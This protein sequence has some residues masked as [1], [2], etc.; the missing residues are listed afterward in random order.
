MFCRFGI[1]G[2]EASG[3]GAGLI[4][5]RVQAPADGM[6][7]ARQHVGIGGFQLGELAIFENFFGHL[8]EERELFENVG[9]GGTRFWRSVRGEASADR[10]LIEKHFGELLRRIDFELEAGQFVDAFFQA[11]DF[12]LRARWR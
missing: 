2:A 6:N 8:V 9:G 1:G 7:Q 12:L 4:E 11:G 10:D 3:G 5:A